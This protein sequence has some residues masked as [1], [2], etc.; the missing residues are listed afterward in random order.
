M[1]G[2]AQL[3]WLLCHL[4]QTEGD[5]RHLEARGVS[6]GLGH[7]RLGAQGTE[8]RDRSPGTDGDPSYKTPS[9]TRGLGLACQAQEDFGANPRAGPTASAMPSRLWVCRQQRPRGGSADP[10]ATTRGG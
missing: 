10:H 2:M 5:S 1:A 6:C 9:S 8:V 7:T 3:A 4:D